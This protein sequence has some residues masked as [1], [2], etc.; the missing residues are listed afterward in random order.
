MNCFNKGNWSL[1]QNSMVSLWRVVGAGFDG[2]LA[3]LKRP[4]QWGHE[5]LHQGQQEPGAEQHA[6]PNTLG[7]S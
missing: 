3:W 1:V 7:G 4:C 2:G 6:E 5:P